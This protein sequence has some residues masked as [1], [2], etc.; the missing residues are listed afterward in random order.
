MNENI[1]KR[2]SCKLRDEISRRQEEIESLLEKLGGYAALAECVVD[3]VVDVVSDLSPE[4]ER[5]YNKALALAILLSEGLEGLTES[6]SCET[7]K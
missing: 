2:C 6:A 4:N 1:C 7:E 3:A 5:K